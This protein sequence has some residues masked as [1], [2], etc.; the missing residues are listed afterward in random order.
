M[1][2]KPKSNPPT[3]RRGFVPCI[4]RGRRRKVIPSRPSTP[5]N[6]SPS[7]IVSLGVGLLLIVGITVGLLVVLNEPPL[8]ISRGLNPQGTFHK[9]YWPNVE[10]ANAPEVGSFAFYQDRQS[11]KIE[12]TNVVTDVILMVLYPSLNLGDEICLCVKVTVEGGSPESYGIIF[13]S[14]D[15]KNFQYIDISESKQIVNFGRVV[16]GQPKD[17]SFFMPIGEILQDISP[18][19]GRQIGLAISLQEVHAWLDLHPLMIHERGNR[20]SNKI[21][22]FV[23]PGR[24]PESL[25]LRISFSDLRVA[26]LSLK[27]WP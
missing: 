27:C 6:N 17:M 5:R 21:G 11:Y 4:L 19:Q 14:A 13:D 22:L 7:L 24:E 10:T 12:A 20:I 2:G 25:P 9:A 3:P 15:S 1:P 26:P 16:D 23:V 18:G 8:P